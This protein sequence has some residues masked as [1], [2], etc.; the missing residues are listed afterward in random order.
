M[1]KAD[2][3]YGGYKPPKEEKRHPLTRRDTTR[4]Y[5]TAV[6]YPDLETE[7]CVRVPLD[8]G[9][10]MGELTHC[11][12]HWIEQEYNREIGG[13][14]YRIRIP[15][16]ENC[17]GGKGGSIGKGNPEG[18]NLHETNNPCAKCV[19]RSWEGKVDPPG[20]ERGWLTRDQAEKYD[21]SP[22]QARSATKV[23]AFPQI[24]DA[25]KTAEKLKKFLQAQNHEQWPH[26]AGA[27]RT[28]IDKVADKAELSLPDRSQPKIVMHA[29]RHTYGCRLV[30]MG[31]GEG[32]A[33]EQ[34]R[35]ENAD[36]F[37]WYAQVRGA[38][39][40]SALNDAVS[41]SDSLL[42]RDL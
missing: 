18:V 4:L 33:M 34:M 28:R 19:N 29:L 24:P 10:R 20:Q 15:K 12:A 30:E 31:V 11:R 39:V 6:D 7:L 21:Y 27:V 14:I 5:Q 38:R 40:V 35:H 41:E 36:V 3:G 26:T 2:S 25:N 8:F 9:L 22:K 37:R 1:S 13:Q 32:A 16:V 23:W 17:W 42:H